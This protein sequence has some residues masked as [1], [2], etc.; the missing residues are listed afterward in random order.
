MRVE[1]DEGARRVGRDGAP[2]DTDGPAPRRRNTRI[3]T[4]KSKPTIQ[5]NRLA[6]AFAK[7]RTHRSERA[8]G[9]ICVRSQS[10]HKQTTPIALWHESR[11]WQCNATHAL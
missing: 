1:H 2:E 6:G 9:G 5:I 3:E 10:K 4:E 7:H 11:E 8:S